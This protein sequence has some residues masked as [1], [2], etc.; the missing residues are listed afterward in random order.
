MTK[1]QRLMLDFCAEKGI[2]CLDVLD[3]LR[4]Q[5]KEDLLFFRVDGHL[6]AAG[7]RVMGQALTDY[8][9][10]FLAPDS[11]PSAAELPS[12]SARK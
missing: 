8:L 7:H 2:P 11:A 1:P 10:E 6:N 3:P 4:E 9:A 12:T 5:G